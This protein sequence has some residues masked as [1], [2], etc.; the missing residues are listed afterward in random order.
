P[1]VNK[2]FR[3]L[4]K[5]QSNYKPL[6]TCKN[7]LPLL[8]YS[9][10]EGN[11]YM[12]YSS[13]HPDWGSFSSDALFSTML[14]RMSELSQ[15]TQPIALTIG[16][17]K[18]YPVYSKENIDGVLTLSNGELEF[19]PQTAVRS[20]V[21]YISLNQL[22]NFQSLT[23]GTYSITGEKKIGH[24]SMNYD[25]SESKLNYFTK[26]Q[27]IDIFK[28]QGAKEV[29]FKAIDGINTPLSDLKIDNPFS[30]WKICIVLTLIFVLVEMLL[31]RF[32]KK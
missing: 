11:A 14:L 10:Q 32:Y 31:I 16:E 17:Q 7:G 26:N 12:F 27:I 20:G 19:I 25:R 18:N 21:S 3:P 2:A 6:F 9:P 28:T 13:I 30:Y 1:S 29:T 22:G 15:R 5:R 4:I 8:V 24:I 23:A